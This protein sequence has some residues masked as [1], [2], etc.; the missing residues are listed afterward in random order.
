MISDVTDA[1]GRKLDLFMYKGQR[2]LLSSNAKSM[3]INQDKPGIVSWWLWRKAMKMWAGPG[4]VIMIL[5]MIA[6]VHTIG[7]FLL[8][9]HNPQHPSTFNNSQH[10]QWTPTNKAAPRKMTCHNGGVYSNI[11]EMG[12]R[13]YRQYGNMEIL[14]SLDKLMVFMKQGKCLIAT[15]GSASDNMMSFAWKV[16]DVGGNGYFCHAGLAFGK[17]SSF[18]AE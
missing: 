15:D 13:D 2:S 16:V 12:T 9:H 18:R 5:Q 14:V 7:G 11:G 10:V 8:Y 6:Y 17:E 3:D 4:L 1:G